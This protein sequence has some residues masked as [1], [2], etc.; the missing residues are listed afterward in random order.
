MTVNMNENDNKMREKEKKREQKTR[1]K[2][3]NISQKLNKK[4][5]T[6]S[7][8][9]L[10]QEIAWE[11]ERRQNFNKAKIQRKS[12]VTRD[13]RDTRNEKKNNKTMNRKMNKCLRLQ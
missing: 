7:C 6:F 3:Y 4:L 2:R 12:N 5:E 1:K 10:K 13:L 8:N 9:I 11:R